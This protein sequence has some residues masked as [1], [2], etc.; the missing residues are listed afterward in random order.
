MLRPARGHDHPHPRILNVVWTKRFRVWGLGTHSSNHHNQ[1]D[2]SL[3]T[4]ITVMM[5]KITMARMINDETMAKLNFEE[6]LYKTSLCEG[7]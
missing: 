3:V 4:I 1:N 6:G 5:M 2:D 7:C